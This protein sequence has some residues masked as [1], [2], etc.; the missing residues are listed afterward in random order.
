MGD[1]VAQ[2]LQ[3]SF[4]E[5]QCRHADAD[6]FALMGLRAVL[7]EHAGRFGLCLRGEEPG[8][9]RFEQGGREFHLLCPFVMLVMRP[10]DMSISCKLQSPRPRNLSFR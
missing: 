6:L 10:N 4:A 7:G 1:Q 5:L 3:R 2:P 8:D 9:K